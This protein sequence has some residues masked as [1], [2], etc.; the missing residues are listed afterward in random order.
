MNSKPFDLAAA[1]RGEPVVTANGNQVAIIDFNVIG[2]Y[3][4]LK[5]LVQLDG[6]RRVI[7][8][9]DYGNYNVDGDPSP[10]DLRMATT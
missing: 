9:T 10:Y 4:H 8:Y 7:Y 6:T 1:K 3:F 5:A 2:H